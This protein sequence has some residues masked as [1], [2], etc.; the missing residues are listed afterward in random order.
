MEDKWRKSQ[1]SNTDEGSFTV[2][3]VNQHTTEDEDDAAG[4]T[5]NSAH[6]RL[7]EDDMNQQDR[8]GVSMNLHSLNSHQ[9]MQRDAVAATTVDHAADPSSMLQ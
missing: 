4:T 8:E 2:T 1:L 9:M 7:N 5:E 3:Q 6:D